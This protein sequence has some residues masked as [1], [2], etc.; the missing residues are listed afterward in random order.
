MYN[1]LI[2]AIIKIG[3]NPDFV[4]KIEPS[5]FS[6]QNIGSWMVIRILTALELLA[7][8]DGLS[9]NPGV[10]IQEIDISDTRA[11]PGNPECV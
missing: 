1:D 6:H 10:G 2:D 11:I 4:K 9:E 5:L 7:N 3:N 8:E